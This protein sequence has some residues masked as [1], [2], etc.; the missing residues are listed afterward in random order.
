MPAGDRSMAWQEIAD[1]VQQGVWRVTMGRKDGLLNPDG[2]RWEAMPDLSN[3]SAALNP[4]LSGGMLLMSGANLAVSIDSNRRLRRDR[5]A[6]LGDAERA[7]A[8]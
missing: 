5:G 6:D 4:L 2:I 8:R 3:V 1:G 7:H